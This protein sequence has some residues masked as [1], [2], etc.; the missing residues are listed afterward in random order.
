VQ[1]LTSI[2]FLTCLCCGLLGYH[3]VFHVQLAAVKS[4]MKA[5]LRNQQHNKNIVQIRLSTEELKHLHWE[6]EHEFR[7]Q[8]KMYDVIEMKSGHGIVLIRCIADEKETALLN[9]YQKNKKEN[10][11]NSLIFQLITAAYILPAH[12]LVQQPEKII[13]LNFRDHS[14]S[15][16]DPVSVVTQPPPNFIWPYTN[17]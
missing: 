10:P 16:Q 15:L 3:L 9:E 13:K 12:F 14:P 7:Y 6:D 11:S 8:G 1:K 17:S 4:E 2:F 5:F